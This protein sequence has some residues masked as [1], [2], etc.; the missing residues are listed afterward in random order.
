MCPKP[1]IFCEAFV[2]PNDILCFPT[3]WDTCYGISAF[4]QMSSGMPLAEKARKTILTNYYGVL[5]V[6]NAFWSLIQSDG[7]YSADLILSQN[8][9]IYIDFSLIRIVNVSSG[10]GEI[11]AVSKKIQDEILATDI[12]IDKLSNIMDQYV[13]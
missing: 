2:I 4:I 13:K 3:G 11:S 10:Y 8:I 6:T 7:R 1:Y 12:T 5:N 9:L